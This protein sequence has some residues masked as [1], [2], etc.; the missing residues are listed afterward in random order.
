MAKE[1][2]MDRKDQIIDWL[3][4]II[5]MLLI[6][7][8]GY[9]L[10]TFVLSNNPISGDSM[11]PNFQ[12]GQRVI[13]VRHAQIRRGDVVIIDAPDKPGEM[14]IKRVIGLPGEKLV[15]KNQQIYIN[16][17]KLSQPWL[18]QARRMT[19]HQKGFAGLKYSTTQNFDLKMLAKTDQ[20]AEN[21]PVKDVDYILKTG[22][23]PKGTYF[24]M[25]DHRS[26][27]NDSRYIGVIPKSK[28][29]GVAKLRYW[30]L[31]KISIIDNK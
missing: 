15:S 23:I 31:N 12:N 22:R 7:L 19:D 14:Y 9:L 16:G 3:K 28:I 30:P 25:G 13:A 18:D 26:I 24:V 11:Q 27:S 4:T 10:N 20:F 17:N 29:V 2:K 1:E 5:I 6:F 8:A 21:T